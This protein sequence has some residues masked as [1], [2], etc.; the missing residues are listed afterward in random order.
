MSQHKYK[1]AALL[2]EEIDLLKGSPLFDSQ[3]YRST[4]PDV[5]LSGLAP[6]EHFLRYGGLLGRDPGP[7]FNS[8]LYSQRFGSQIPPDTPPLIYHLHQAPHTKRKPVSTFRKK[9]WSGFSEQGLAGLRAVL[10]EPAYH[11][12][13]KSEA[14]VNLARWASANGQWDEAVTLLEQAQQITTDLAQSEQVVLLLI[15]ALI[16]A[17][18]FETAEMQLAQWQADR[19]GRLSGNFVC[20]K[21]NLLMLKGGTEAHRQRVTLL[22]DHFVAHGLSPISLAVQ[23]KGL[24]FGNI[25]FDP[26]AAPVDGPKVSVLMP[27]YN[28]GAFI[29]VA[30]RSLLTQT[31]QN[32]EIVAIED[33]GTDDSWERLQ[34]FAAE[35]DRVRV[36][37]NDVNMGAYPTRNR[38]L[39]Q[40]TG[41]FITVHDSDDWSHPQMIEQQVLALQQNPSVKAICSAMARVHPDMDFIQR[42]KRDNPVYIHRSY[43][44]LMIRRDDLTELGEWDSVS[45]N[46]D[47]EMMH[48]IRALWGKETLSDALPDVPLSFFLVHENSLT[49]QA[50]TNLNSVSFGIRKEYNRQAGYWRQRTEKM[51]LVRRDMKTPFPIPQG[52][53]PRNWPRNF[54]YDV[55]LVSDF[56]RTGLVQANNLSWLHAAHAMGL[57]VGLFNWPRVDHSLNDLLD[58]Y[59]D[60]T[61]H[62]NFD[63]LVPEDKV[64]CD[65]VLVSHAA[66]LDQ[67]I[68][69]TPTI[70]TDQVVIQA[71]ILHEDRWS[72]PGPVRDHVRRATQRCRTLFGQEPTWYAVGA[73]A[74]QL[75]QIGEHRP[76]LHSDTWYPAL[77]VHRRSSGRGSER[78]ERDIL[79][80][81]RGGPKPV[82]W[83]VAKSDIKAAFCANE[84]GISM[85][86]EAGVPE[87]LQKMKTTP[88]NWQTMSESQPSGS[89]FYR[90]LDFYVAIGSEAAIQPLLLEALQAMAHGV[91]VIAPPHDKDLLGPT[92]LYAAP[93]AVADLVRS[94]WQDPARYAAQVA[95]GLDFVQDN[96]NSQLVEDR[97]RTLLT[98]PRPQ[99]ECSS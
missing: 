78:G 60:L 68:D 3:W 66:V 49:Q 46:A 41:D 99:G 90:D 81:T 43:P 23:N 39:H 14:A 29:E 69:A 85:H 80:G 7:R 58:A 27:V 19:G 86:F 51:D 24:V 6:E 21:S 47:S 15:E 96:C 55:V 77:K 9:L 53:A 79:I 87:P 25:R 88:R 83:P 72:G 63:I 16:R 95:A 34:A 59:L 54:H 35:D 67:T 12:Q 56:G 20:A 98:A 62:D 33:H 70:A 17:G 32:L 50:G 13:G 97:L 76:D 91:V 94:V 57:R 2:S 4:Y 38:A 71:D 26:P 10:A 64:T 48:R 89:G 42:P 65:L 45:A 8:R 18:R 84:P 36:F 28:A 37:R 1:T 61:Y 30:M 82:F 73:R 92:A 31:W 5:D 75:L 74:A 40:A 22:N 44:S 52:L 93:G 11:T